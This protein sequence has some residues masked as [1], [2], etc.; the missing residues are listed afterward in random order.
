MVD[1][2][3]RRG[4]VVDASCPLRPGEPCTLCVPEADGPHNCPTVALV[5]DD[6]DLRLQWTARRAQARIGK[7]L[8]GS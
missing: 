1:R 5:M 4:R 8:D 3:V 7:H 2:S 6:D